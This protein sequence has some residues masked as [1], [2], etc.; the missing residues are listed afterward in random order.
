MHYQKTT[1][2]ALVLS[3]PETSKVYVGFPK[4]FP[5][6]RNGNYYLTKAYYYVRK[7]CQSFTHTYGLCVSPPHKD[8]FKV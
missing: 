3:I 6:K 1:E 7:P 2:S 8:M 5:E 4:R